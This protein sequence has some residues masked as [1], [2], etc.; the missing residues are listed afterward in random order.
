MT[1][2][3]MIREFNRINTLGNNAYCRIRDIKIMGRKMSCKKMVKLLEEVSHI[4][5]PSFFSLEAGTKL[6]KVDIKSAMDNAI[7][8]LE[9]LDQLENKLLD[10]MVD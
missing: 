2:L 5:M 1:K 6:T 3:E 10:T 9:L 8:G 7:I 4:I